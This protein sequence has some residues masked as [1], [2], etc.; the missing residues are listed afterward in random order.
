MNA[1]IATRPRRLALAAATFLVAV[2]LALVLTWQTDPSNTPPC[3]RR[4][5]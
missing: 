2:L 1:L 3:P 5:S 4:I